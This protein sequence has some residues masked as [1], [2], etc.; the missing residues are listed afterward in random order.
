VAANKKLQCISGIAFAS[1]KEWNEY[2]TMLEKPKQ[3]NH[4]KLGKELK[5]SRSMM[6]LARERYCGHQGELLFSKNSKILSS[7]NSKDKDTN[8]YFLYT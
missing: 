8:N 2:L 1:E 3:G 6:N 7:K 4:R 5:L